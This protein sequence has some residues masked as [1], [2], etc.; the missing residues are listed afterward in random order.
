MF[1]DEKYLRFSEKVLLMPSVFGSERVLRSV[2]NINSRVRTRLTDRHLEGCMR[3]VATEI[4]PD[5]EKLMKLKQCR[6]SQ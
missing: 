4:K 1:Y 2:K 5:T 3:I 6:I